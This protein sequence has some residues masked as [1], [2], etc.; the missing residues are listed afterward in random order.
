ML[1]ILA[2]LESTPL[3]RGRSSVQS[4]PAAPDFLEKSEP[5]A[6]FAKRIFGNC[7]QN[8]TRSPHL[9]TGKIRGL[10]SQPVQAE[11]NERC[12]DSASSKLWPN[13]AAA[14]ARSV[15]LAASPKTI[16]VLDV[17]YGFQLERYA[18][19]CGRKVHLL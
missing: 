6:L 11:R 10:C 14:M 7:E 1:D 8:E 5:V 4:T 17:A 13:R 16:D 19:G 3:V 9:N 12:L 15:P 18:C 2:Q